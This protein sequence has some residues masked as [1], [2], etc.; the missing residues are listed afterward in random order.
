MSKEF[1]T[2]PGLAPENDPASPVQKPGMK[3][4]EIL[5]LAAALIAAMV[6]VLLDY[7]PPDSRWVPILGFILAA[8]TY[9]GGRSYV[10]AS[11]NTAAALVEASKQGPSKPQ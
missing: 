3:T 4:T 6:P 5:A 2:G 1:T 7:I 11:G 9:I 8:A 10:K